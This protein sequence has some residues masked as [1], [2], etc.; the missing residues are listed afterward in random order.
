MK[1]GI[2]TYHRCHNYGA[3]LQAVAMRKVLGDIGNNVS[4]VDYWPYEHDQRYRIINKVYLNKVDLL[5][6]MTYLGRI[7]KNLPNIKRRISVFRRFIDRHID[8]YCESIDTQYDCVVYGSDQIWRKE[9]SLGIR[10][11]SI[12]LGEGISDDIS[13]ISYAASMGVLNLED[14]DYKELYKHLSKFTGVSVRENDLKNVVEKAGIKNVKQV[15]DPTLLLTKED[16]MDLLKIKPVRK[17][18]YV[19]YYGLMPGS[20]DEDELR[21]FAR[22]RN[23]EFV[24]L[25][26]TADTLFPKKNVYS[27]A[28]PEEMLSL[29]ANADYVFTSSYHGL[30]FSLIFQKEVYAAFKTNAGRA[31]TLLDSLNISGRLLSPNTK[32]CEVDKIP[33]NLVASRMAG[34]RSD[35]LSWIE[36]MLENARAL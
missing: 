13:K 5:H 1:I 8:P 32:V 29:I 7:G 9:P 24:E 36:K 3:L 33:Y 22:K 19:L 2:L 21:K 30:V 15:L 16:W 31:K 20:F 23:L 12:Y 25:K 14:S 6:K 11:D 28:G 18:G 4:Y 27:F 10:I 17:R 26:G 35:S 34:L